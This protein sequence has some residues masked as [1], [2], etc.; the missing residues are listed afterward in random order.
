MED[1]VGPIWDPSGCAGW[2]TTLLLQTQKEEA[3]LQRQSRLYSDK[4]ASCLVVATFAG[5][6]SCKGIS[7]LI[8]VFEPNQPLGIISEL[9]VTL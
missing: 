2:S 6:C 7:E 9:K 4:T 1:Y 8:G 3:V 5:N